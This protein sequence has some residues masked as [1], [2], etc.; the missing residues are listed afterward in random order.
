MK[1]KII[2]IVFIAAI[3]LSTG[4]FAQ[5]REYKVTTWEMIFSSS[6]IQLSDAFHLEYPDAEITKTDVRYT[7]FFHLGEY[8]NFNF[9]NNFGFY[10]GLGVR[11]VGLISD[12][13]L[14]EIVG[15][16]Q[17]VDYKIVRRL[18]TIGAPLAFKLGSFKDN[19]YFYA[20]GECELALVYKEKYWTG[21]QTRAGEMKK[22]K[23]WFGDQTPA[24]LPSVFA[25]VKLPGGVSAS[26]KYYL[27]DF[28]NHNYSKKDNSV[29]G[30]PYNISDLSR[31]KLSQVFYLS[32]SWQINSDEI[33]HN[34]KNTDSQLALK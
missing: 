24:F 26:F 22:N 9:G 16:P 34:M 25:G 28:L 5:F 20:G 31:Y 2:L 17:L 23:T 11:N 21:T 1:K 7:L 32:L 10:T 14:P 18:Y 29:I 27:D 19:L 30:N 12:E 3:F 8:W 15:S 33:I 6:D 13:R 4:V